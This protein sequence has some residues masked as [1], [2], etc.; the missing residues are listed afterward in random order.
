LNIRLS[1]D[2]QSCLQEALSSLGSS[3]D[4]NSL[5]EKVKSNERYLQSTRKIVLSALRELSGI[6]E[7][8]RPQVNIK[9]QRITII[10]TKELSSESLGDYIIA[11]LENQRNVQ[12]NLMTALVFETNSFP[13]IDEQSPNFQ[14][15]S[16]VLRMSRKRNVLPIII[17]Q[18]ITEVPRAFLPLFATWAMFR[19]TTPADLTTTRDMGLGS[20]VGMIQMFRRGEFLLYG[21]G[22]AMPVPQLISLE[23]K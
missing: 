17:S 7:D 16:E 22:S 2:Q 11:I 15:M 19:I 12:P 8:L 10:P 1:P 13:F 21:A 14:L 4:I 6:L 20:Y 23:V 5:I 3:A 18:T 9:S